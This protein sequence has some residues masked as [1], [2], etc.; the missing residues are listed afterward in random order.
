L[1]FPKQHAAK[2]RQTVIRKQNSSYSKTSEPAE[3]A[4]RGASIILIDDQI[5]PAVPLESPTEGQLG[6][7]QYNGVRKDGINVRQSPISPTLDYYDDIME[8]VL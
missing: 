6:N 8:N 7:W 4:D 2:Q 1:R 3:G 5:S